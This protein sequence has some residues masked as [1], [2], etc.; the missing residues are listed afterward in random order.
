MN[1]KTLLP[2]AQTKKVALTNLLTLR[3]NEPA[4][5]FARQQTQTR[6]S[7]LPC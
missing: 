5:E 7:F 4:E 2:N 3:Q 6:Y 1:R